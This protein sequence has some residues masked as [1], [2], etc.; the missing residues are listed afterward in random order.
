MV[1]VVLGGLLGVA[2]LGWFWVR[3]FQPD[4]WAWLTDDPEVVDYLS[5]A[6]KVTG[7]LAIATGVLTVVVAATAFR[8]GERWAWLVFLGWPL[9]LV[10]LASVFPWMTPFL[11]LL[12]AA[13]VGALVASFPR[14]PAAHEAV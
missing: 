11:I 2:G 3:E 5:F 13:A 12:G 1:F 14:R 4:H 10:G 9:L 8:R 6:W 7:T